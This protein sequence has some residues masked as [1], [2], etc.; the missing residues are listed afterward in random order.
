M[1]AESRTA[2]VTGGSRGIGR[3]IAEALAKAGLRVAIGY[4]ERRAEADALAARI[5]AAEIGRAHV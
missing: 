4:R 1:T 2:I 5:H 3:A